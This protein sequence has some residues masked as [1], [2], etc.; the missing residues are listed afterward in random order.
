MDFP[1]KKGS[2]PIRERSA[3]PTRKKS[4]LN[5]GSFNSIRSRYIESVTNASENN[6][7]PMSR[8]HPSIS[9]DRRSRLLPPSV[10]P[11]SR[12]KQSLEEPIEEKLE[13]DEP[14]MH[15]S[16]KKAVNNTTK[17]NFLTD[18]E[19]NNQIQTI[20]NN[21]LLLK[22]LLLSVASSVK[23]S[24]TDFQ[25]LS[26]STKSNNE[27]IAKLLD[28]FNKSKSQSSMSTKDMARFYDALNSKFDSS[29]RV[30]DQLKDISANIKSLQSI[31]DHLQKE[32]GLSESKQTEMTYNIVK[33]NRAE[34]LS[35]LRE[36]GNWKESQQVMM[37][38]IENQINTISKGDNSKDGLLMLNNVS[39]I[40]GEQLYSNNE[41]TKKSFNELNQKITEM[42]NAIE[43]NKQHNTS[44]EN[45]SH[46][47]SNFKTDVSEKISLVN[48]SLYQFES[49]NELLLNKI[50]AELKE[51][52]KKAF[53]EKF[54]SDED[55]NLLQDR[56][57][58]WSGQVDKNISQLLISSLNSKFQ[59]G[60]SETIKDTL[61]TSLESLHNELIAEK[62]D[63]A[64]IVEKEL[65]KMEG[66]F[67]AVS[68]SPSRLMSPS[69]SRNVENSSNMAL[70]EKEL[71]NKELENQLQI[72][73]NRVLQERI[74]EL[75]LAVEGKKECENREKRILKLESKKTE[76][77]TE[78]RYLNEIYNTRYNDLE[79]LRKKHDELLQNINN[80][81]LDKYKNIFGA[82]AM[83]LLNRSNNLSKNT[84]PSDS[85]SP[86]NSPV[87]STSP[88]A[89]KKVL[90]PLKNRIARANGANLKST[91]ET[92]KVLGGRNFSLELH[93]TEN[94][95]NF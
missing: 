34:A 57:N 32:G 35:I 5:E 19:I 81:M 58:K 83:A 33:A 70:L 28:S 20:L 49:K 26:K 71:K 36:I 21:G 64:K 75:E 1:E 85:F 62:S 68:A 82:S 12:R 8:R 69:R 23:A 6:T 88:K 4:R 24:K 14:S 65:S 41:K 37:K 56:L 89:D 55:F 67:S 87:R 63:I 54:V 86:A 31:L 59:K 22:N 77:K 61:A 76:L 94:K 78:L 10:S 52:M 27:E 46:L 51:D 18:L 9:P 84:T 50:S 79:A 29:S 74:R 60:L 11:E 39:Q 25:E 17:F 43:S 16:A 38:K 72:K 73:E 13:V 80:M 66:K 3:S 15:A 44:D 30:N 93:K 92:K 2:S 7:S 90:S 48:E 42:K 95:E 45:L 47:V 91:A 40:V 53:I